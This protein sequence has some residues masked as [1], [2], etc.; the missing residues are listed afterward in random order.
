LSSFSSVG[1]S[2]SQ[3]LSLPIDSNFDGDIV[4]FEPLTGGPNRP[5]EV[6]F[7]ATGHVLVVAESLGLQT[8]PAEIHLPD[9]SETASIGYEFEPVTSGIL[10]VE[11]VNDAEMITAIGY[12]GADLNPFSG[13]GESRIAYDEIRIEVVEND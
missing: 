8:Q 7:P 3:D 2:T 10:R 6:R 9:D 13:Q 12:V 1:I 5:S 11:F 4:G